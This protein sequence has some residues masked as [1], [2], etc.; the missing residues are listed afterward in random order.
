MATV[1]VM[2]NKRTQSRAGLA[3]ILSYC[4]R[5][6]KT[7]HEGKKLVS[8]VNCLPESAYREFMNTK[9]QYGK[10]DGR[11]FYHF[12]QSFSPTE[13]ITPE[14]AHEIAVRFAEKMFPGF[15]VLVATHTDK[16]H[17]H[18]HFVVNS[19]SCENGYKYH[20]DNENIERLRAESDKLCLQY[21]LSVLPPKEQSQKVKQMSSREYRAAER[22]ESWKM[23]LIVTIEDAMAIARSR[24]HFI[25]LMEAEGYEV[26]WTR[27]RKSITYSTPDGKRCRDNKLHEEKFLKENME[28][29]F[30][31]RNEI[32]RGIKGYGESAYEESGNVRPL[33]G[34]HGCELEG[35]DRCDE[36]ADRYACSDTEIA[37]GAGNQGGHHLVYGWADH[38]TDR[39]CREQSGADR[40]VHGDDGTDGGSIYRE[41]EYGNREYV[42]TGWESERELFTESLF[43]TG[44]GES[45]H[46]AEYTDWAY[47][48]GSADHLGTDTAYLFADLTNIIDEDAPVEDCTTT[49]YPTERKKKHGP[50]MGGM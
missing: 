29:E 47:P 11:M 9:L 10:T 15:E 49:H 39:V 33:Y 4:K 40:T 7:V 27:D 43:G 18:S 16:A 26:K 25:R 24:E 17:I 44:N 28:Y 13:D 6:S 48:D 23:Q 45:V 37:D 50:V 34:D 8:G 46:Q 1:N 19:V 32:S 42:L 20:S 21:G 5:E 22:G 31:I 38:D 3:F 12:T 14:T 30:R 2:K 35:T 36:Y 41:D